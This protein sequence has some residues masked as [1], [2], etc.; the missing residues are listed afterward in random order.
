L[1][2]EQAKNIIQR[3]KQQAQRIIAQADRER[4][5]IENQRQKIEQMKADEEIFI[6]IQSEELAKSLAINI[7]QAELNKSEIYQKYIQTTALL[8]TVNKYQTNNKGDRENENQNDKHS[9][10]GR[11]Y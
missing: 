1:A 4:Q 3:A 5:E 7:A 8:D 6:R 11:F 9:D 10:Y 2:E